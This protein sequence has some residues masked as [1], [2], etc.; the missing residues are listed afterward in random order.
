[1]TFGSPSTLPCDRGP[2]ARRTDPPRDR[3]PAAC[4]ADSARESAPG[5]QSRSPRATPPPVAVAGAYH[6]HDGCAS[7]HPRQASD[8]HV[9]ALLAHHPPDRQH[10]RSPRREC[11]ACAPLRHAPESGQNVLG[12]DAVGNDLRLAAGNPR[13][14]PARPAPASNRSA[15]SVAPERVRPDAAPGLLGHEDIAAVQPTA[16]GT[17]R[18]HQRATAFG[19]TQWAWTQIESLPASQPRPPTGRP[20]DRAA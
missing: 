20:P 10:H 18:Q 5:S 13:R 3:D 17:R 8:Q 6:V 15:Q 14:R 7:Q 16:S 1:M 2:P 9:V 11:P 12:I 19:T 4:R